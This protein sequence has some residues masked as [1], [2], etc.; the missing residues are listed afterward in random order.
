MYYTL[1]SQLYTC[2]HG[3][4]AADQR[5]ANIRMGEAAGQLRD[6]RFRLGRFFRPGRTGRT[7]GAITVTAPV[8][9]LSANR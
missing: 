1:S 3:R 8:Q 9:A 5:A 4:T 2:D 7:S 6:L